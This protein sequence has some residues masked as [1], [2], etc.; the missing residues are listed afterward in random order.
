M[1]RKDREV[2][3]KKVILDI[4]QKCQTC[5]IGLH[6]EP[7]PY[8]VPVN[9]GFEVLNDMIVIYFHGAAVGKKTDLI[10]NNPNVCVEMDTEGPLVTSY[11][12][13]ECTMKYE[14][15]IGFGKAQILEGE[16]KHKALQIIVGKYHKNGF[17][18][19]E[20]TVPETTVVK[21]ELTDYSAKKN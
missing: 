8:I 20:S 3:D 18:F 16:E 12:N 19:N 13:K 11:K 6:D 5:R 2:K 21:I 14:S 17:E 10:Q 4:L 7:Y 15:I 1:I 9:F